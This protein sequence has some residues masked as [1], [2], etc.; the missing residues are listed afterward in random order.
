MKANLTE[1]LFST[2]K[3][4]SERAKDLKTLIMGLS[5]LE[6]FYLEDL[7]KIFYFIEKIANSSSEKVLIKQPLTKQPEG[8][9]F[10]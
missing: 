1:F 5:Q 8:R 7:H 3:S 4:C 9:I 2:F 6:I 10:S